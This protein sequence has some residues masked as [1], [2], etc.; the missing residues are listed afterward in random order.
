MTNSSLSSSTPRL[1]AYAGN[2]LASTRD[3]PVPDQFAEVP[4]LALP[5]PRAL[6]TGECGP[7]A[8]SA[9]VRKAGS[10]ASCRA[11]R[12]RVASS[13]AIDGTMELFGEMSTQHEIDED[14]TLILLLAGGSNNS[15]YWDWPLDPERH[16]FVRHATNAGFVTLNL[17]RPGYGKSDRPD[18]TRMD[19]RA[20]AEAVRQ[21]MAQLKSGAIGHRFKKVVVNGNSMGGMV[22]WHSVVDPSP[23]DAVI[24]SGVGHGLSDLAMDMVLN[25]L[26][27]VEEHPSFGL[28]CGLLPG[29]FIRRLSPALPASGHDLYTLL[30]QDTVML[31]ELKAI[32]PDS[33]NVEITK[34]IRVPVL[35][36]LGRHDL[37][38]CTTTGDCSTDP[39]F[40][41]EPQKYRPETDVTTFLV[42]EAGHLINKDPGAHFF[43]EKTIAWLQERG[44]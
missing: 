25:A 41:N 26:Q 8:V 31:A 7:R 35:F 12:F 40:L 1:S 17:D 20:Q 32:K 4:T 19:F 11:Y 37:R 38:W 2:D 44:F 39:V 3:I 23:A 29:Y 42:P 30:F 27:P 16:S 34:G 22:A 5:E 33:E 9:T 21:V 10:V 18:P 15:S 24:V 36:A 13:A 6:A 14:S 43:F 28:G